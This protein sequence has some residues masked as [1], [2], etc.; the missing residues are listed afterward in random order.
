MIWD[1]YFEN[2]AKN[3][4]NSVLSSSEEGNYFLQTID[5]YN[6]NQDLCFLPDLKN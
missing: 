6:L 1:L 2:T 3:V 4:C 5:Q